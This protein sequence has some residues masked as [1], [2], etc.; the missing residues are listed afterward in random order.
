MNIKLG[1]LPN[2]L[3]SMSNLLQK[4]MPIKISYKLSKLNKKLVEEYQQ[5][6]ES[7]KLLINKYALKDSE[8]N[9]VTQDNIVQFNQDNLVLF[10]DEFEELLNIEFEIDFECIKIDDLGDINISPIDLM[11]LEDFI[12]E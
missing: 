12:V 6:E 1:N 9:I 7:R 4:E 3:E 11:I 5:F 2:I 8:D 10:N